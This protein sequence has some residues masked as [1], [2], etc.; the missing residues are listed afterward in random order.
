MVVASN[1]NLGKLRKVLSEPCPMCGKLLEL[2]S[3]A[4]PSIERGE[5]YT[6]REDKIICSKCAY[7]RKPNKSKNQWHNHRKASRRDSEALE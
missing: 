7:T 1:N 4:V 5:E 2:R 6:M 3:I